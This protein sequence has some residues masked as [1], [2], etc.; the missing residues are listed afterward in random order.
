MVPLRAD[1]NDPVL[2]TVIPVGIEP[3]GVPLSWYST[4]GWTGTTTPS[5][6]V[7]P[8]IVVVPK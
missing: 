4:N 8:L 5:C 7:P 6:N 1:P 2:I 3:P